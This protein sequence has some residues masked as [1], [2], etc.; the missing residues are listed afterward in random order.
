MNPL[1]SV[2]YL[3]GEKELRTSGQQVLDFVSAVDPV[4]G[5]MRGMA[6]SGR[7]FDPE[8]SVEERKA[9]GIEAALETL[10]PVGMGVI[11]ALAKQPAKAV[12]MDTLTLTGAPSDVSTSRN[13]SKPKAPLTSEAKA[14]VESGAFPKPDELQRVAMENN[15]LAGQG[16]GRMPVEVYGELQ[17][18][19]SDEVGEIPTGPTRRQVLA[20]IGSLAIAPEAVLQ[21]GKKVGV[22]AA[23]TP[24]AS[25][26]AGLKAINKGIIPDLARETDLEIYNEQLGYI[27]RYMSKDEIAEEVAAL[28]R[29]TEDEGGVPPREGEYEAVQKR[30]IQAQE[31]YY[32]ESMPLFDEV[33]EASLSEI[34]D[35]DLDSLL[36][37]HRQKRNHSMGYAVTE[38]KMDAIR[39]IIMSK[40]DQ[41]PD[42][43]KS[44]M[45]SMLKEHGKEYVIRNMENKVLNTGE[46]VLFPY[47]DGGRVASRLTGLGSMGYML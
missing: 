28:K 29:I 39:D 10:A 11:G 1:F 22:K 38:E 35:L 33:A 42:Y 26:L 41:L 34:A 8:L 30:L 27:P 14:M 15:I 32:D 4:Q 6:A 43:F 19:Y 16:T 47:A 46:T 17:R 23:L 37:I 7:A 36:I 21:A 45:P 13:F 5:I 40:A 2:G 18:R 24:L 44:A 3:P 9:A 25:R 20:G 31:K 12:L